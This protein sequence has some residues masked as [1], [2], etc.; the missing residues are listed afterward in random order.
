MSARSTSSTHTTRGGTGWFVTSS[1][2]TGS[3]RRIFSTGATA[4]RTGPSPP[5]L[6][7][8]SITLS[9]M[10]PS[11]HATGLRTDG[12]CL[13]S[14]VSV[15]LSVS[16]VPQKADLPKLGQR[17]PL[18]FGRRALEFRFVDLQ[19]ELGLVADLA[20]HRDMYAMDVLPGRDRRLKL[21]FEA[22]ITTRCKDCDVQSGIGGD[23]EALDVLIPEVDGR[24]LLQ[25]CRNEV[26]PD[27]RRG[28]GVDVMVEAIYVVEVG[29]LHCDW[30]KVLVGSVWS[31]PQ[32]VDLFGTVTSV[33]R[34][35]GSAPDR[36]PPHKSQVLRS[37]SDPLA[38]LL[39]GLFPRE[40]GTRASLHRRPPNGDWPPAV[41]LIFGA[42]SLLFLVAGAIRFVQ[43][44]RER[45][46]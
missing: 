40:I 36:C 31:R 17:P 18:T 39:D 34:A 26:I 28:T 46:K 45:T 7:E 9:A 10:A 8:L 19:A 27:E 22:D 23:E 25:P 33:V 44:W 41:T 11:S 43:T 16:T 37:K 12:D 42:W 5:R 2:R 15:V 13:S 4:S 30:L 24:Q 29:Q 3:N 35:L 38:D 32:S 14:P 21:R 6:T 20:D 1:N